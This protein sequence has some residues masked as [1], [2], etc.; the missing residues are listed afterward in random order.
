MPS[1]DDHGPTAEMPRVPARHPSPPM[2]TP[3]LRLRSRASADSYLDGAWWPRSGELAAEL[4][5]LLAVLAVRLGP[6]WRVVYDP[7]CWSSAPAATVVDGATVRLDA[8]RFE[9]WNTLYVFGRDAG[10]IVLQVIPADTDE[11]T[12]H[13]ALMAAAESVAEGPGEARPSVD[14]PA[15]STA[16]AT[17]AHDRQPFGTPTR[18]PR[19]LLRGTDSHAEQFDGAWWPR[20]ANLTAELHDLISAL[21]PRLGKTARI[22]FDWNT[23]SRHQRGIDHGDGVDLH[24]PDVGQQPDAMHL[25]GVDGVHLILL[26]I[27]ADTPADVAD[28]QLLHAVGR[29]RHQLPLSD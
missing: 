6:V 23:T 19:L 18:T 5:D 24:V 1:R 9:R 2:Y 3:R 22:S 21:T 17:L 15:M 27:A 8:Y 26:V 7:T 11:P 20:T 10:M 29:T 16:S 28:A 25:V 4:P 13:A 12:A 14:H